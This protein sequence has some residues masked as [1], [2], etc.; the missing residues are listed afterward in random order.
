MQRACLRVVARSGLALALVLVAPEAYAGLTADEDV[1][2]RVADL[3][4][5]GNALYDQKRLA[6][7]EAVYL[8][9][10]RLKK[11]Y[12]VACNLGALELDLGKRRAAAEYLAYALREFPAGGKA[13]AREQIKNRFTLARAEVGALRVRVN[14]ADARVTV[15][16]RALEKGSVDQE[17]FVEAGTVVIEASALGYGSTRQTVQVAKGGSS[18]VTLTLVEPRRSVVPALVTGGLALVG[19]AAGAGFAAAANG[20]A[21]TAATLRSALGGVP[22]ACAASTTGDCRALADALRSQGTL[23][24]ASAGAFVS[25]GVFA[26]A[27]AGLGIWA[28]GKP[29]RVAPVVGAGER[30]VVVVGTW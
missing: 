30:G 15:G 10:W 9:A 1:S 20:K 26:L 3:Y 2:Q 13:A 28:S 24:K 5:R 7:A 14:V 19:I 11:T 4:K 6:E 21:G 17:V 29:V 27:A 25:G 16:G 8:E 22:S 18:E 12:D 23:A